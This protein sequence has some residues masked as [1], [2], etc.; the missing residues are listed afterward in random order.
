M[1]QGL[2]IFDK[3]IKEMK[4]NAAFVCNVH[5]EWQLE[6]AETDAITVGNL[7]VQSIIEAGEI[8]NLKCPLDGDFNVGKNWSETH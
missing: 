2:I 4:L 5:D 1:K 8:L 6:V 7:G 3:H